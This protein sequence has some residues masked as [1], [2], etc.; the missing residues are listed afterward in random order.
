MLETK[1]AVYIKVDVCLMISLFSFSANSLS[2]VWNEAS[3]SVGLSH[4]IRKI[5][6][7]QDNLICCAMCVR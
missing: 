1:S 4:T 5:H 2:L 3:T 7:E 6:I